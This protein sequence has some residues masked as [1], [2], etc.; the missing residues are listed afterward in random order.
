[1]QDEFGR[2]VDACPL[3]GSAEARWR[4]RRPWDFPLTWLRWIVELIASAFASQR[5]AEERYYWGYGDRTQDE[6][7]GEMSEANTGLRTP[8]RFWKCRACKRKGHE[9]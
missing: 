6:M 8:R 1:M 2:T 4:G 9:F 5:R 7:R 3:C